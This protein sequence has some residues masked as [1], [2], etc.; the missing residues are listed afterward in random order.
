MPAVST[1]RIGP[2]SV[3][4][5]VSMA[6]RVVPGM[7]CTTERSS[8]MSRLNRVDLPT[9]GR[10]TRATENDP[11]ARRPRRRAASRRR[12]RR[13]PSASPSA[14][15]SVPGR[16]ARRRTASS[17]SPVPR[18]CRALTGNGSP[19]PRLIELPGLASAVVVVDLVDH[20]E[21]PEASRRSS[22]ATRASSS[23]T[24]TCVSTTNSTT[25]ASSDGPL[26]LLAHLLVEGA[27][28][29]QPTAGVHHR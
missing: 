29:G 6:S 7:S 24:P 5:T 28:A 21:H 2:S 27:A 25:S 3:S 13:P 11:L 1:K 17:R 20:D 16:A 12:G 26:G 23:V 8:P 14:A 9:L 22:P 18:P 10:P 4:T 15:P 19:R